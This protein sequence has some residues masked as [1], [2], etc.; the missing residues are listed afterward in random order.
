M[1]ALLSASPLPPSGPGAS[2][3]PGG[4]LHP[5][6][7]PP[8]RRGPGGDPRPSSAVGHGPH[9]WAPRLKK[10]GT[11][12]RATPSL[13]IHF[14]GTS[15]NHFYSGKSTSRG[16]L[17][18]LCVLIDWTRNSSVKPHAFALPVTPPHLTSF[19]HSYLLSFPHIHIAP[20][21]RSSAPVGMLAWLLD[22][23]G[24]RGAVC[25]S[26][27]VVLETGF[28]SSLSTRGNVFCTKGAHKM[29]KST[30]TLSA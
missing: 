25:G 22:T 27:P 28:L 18:E 9:P 11:A 10:P 29:P 20:G 15:S 30:I 2:P 1:P 26:A 23:L 5:G 7:P 3:S 12:L 6:S 21:E 16:C 24:D 19:P 14:N 8:A 4:G 13:Y 17:S